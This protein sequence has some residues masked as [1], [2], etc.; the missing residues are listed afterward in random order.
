MRALYQ[1]TVDDDA[2]VVVTAEAL[3][4]A[5]AQNAPEGI[6][7]AFEL[8]IEQRTTICEVPHVVVQRIR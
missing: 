8:R 3:L 6:A 4:E 5:W 2:P 1:V 7:R